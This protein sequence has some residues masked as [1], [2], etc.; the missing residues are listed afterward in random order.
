MRNGLSPGLISAIIVLFSRFKRIQD[1]NGLG[2][3]AKYLKACH[4]YVMQYVSHSTKHSFIT[5]VTYGPHVSLTASGIPRILPNYLRCLIY[6]RDP[7]SIKITLSLLNLYRVLPY[8][9]KVNLQTITEASNA[10]FP[11]GMLDYMPQ[12]WSAF[13]VGPFVYK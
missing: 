3:L 4:I 5:S 1:K 2:Y 8:P 13:A 11:K 12:F 10:K 7:M 9:G 6:R